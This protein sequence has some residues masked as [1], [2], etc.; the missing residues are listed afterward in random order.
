[1]IFSSFE[2]SRAPATYCGVLPGTVDIGKR[3]RVP[4]DAKTKGCPVKAAFTRYPRR[5]DLTEPSE[6]C[7]FGALPGC[8]NRYQEK[9]SDR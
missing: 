9:N 7:R 8:Q 2:H 3:I 4:V 5:D 6:L 1:M